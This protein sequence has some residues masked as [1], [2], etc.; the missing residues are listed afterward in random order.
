MRFF[1]IFAMATAAAAVNLNEEQAAPVLLDDN[2]DNEMIELEDDSLAELESEVEKFS[3]C[4][5]SV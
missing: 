5:P 4:K 3:Y 1:A 2:Q